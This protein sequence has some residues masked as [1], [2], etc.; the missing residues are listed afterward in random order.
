MAH[1]NFVDGMSSAPLTPRFREPKLYTPLRRTGPNPEPQKEVKRPVEAT[2]PPAQLSPHFFEEERNQGHRTELAERDSFAKSQPI[3]PKRKVETKKSKRKVFKLS[4]NLLS[5]QRILFSMAVALFVIGAG[6]S[7]QGY[8]NNKAVKAATGVQAENSEGST[9][10]DKPSEKEPSQWD[11]DNHR[12]AP[13]MPRYLIIDK[14]AI[15]SRVFELGTNQK[16]EL[17]TPDNIYDIGWYNYSARPGSIA[18]ASLMDGHLSGIYNHGVFYDLKTLEVGDII[19]VEKGNG[20]K[21]NYQVASKQVF[22]KDKLPMNDALI[23]AGLDKHGLNLITCAGEFDAQADTYKDRLL[24][25]T[26][27]VEN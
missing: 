1:G 3:Q 25:K 4:K 6:V 18:G 23:S 15:K 22:P 24:M 21:I 2:F 9:N 8:M 19:T 17:D 5:K 27:V 13:D 10:S 14:L 11:I 20:E 16:G 26:V 12:V 7:I